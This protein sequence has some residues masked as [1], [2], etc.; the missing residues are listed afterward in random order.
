[1]SA[2][3]TVPAVR[4]ARVSFAYPGSAAPALEDIHLDVAEGE[5]VVVVGPTGCGKSTFLRAINGLVPHF[6]GGTLRGS[7]E[8]F[9]RST[10]Q[11]PP[12]E[13]A[14]AVGFVP[15]DPAD[16]FVCDSVEEELAYAMENLGVDPVAMRRRVEETLDL[17]SIVDLRDRHPSSLSGGQQQRVAIAAVLTAS[18]RILVL[19]EPTSSLDP[20]SAEEVLASLTRLVHD[21]GLTVIM[22]EHRLERVAHL[23]DRIVVVDGPRTAAELP[24]DAMT[25]SPVAPPVVELGRLAGWHPL[26]L[27]IRDARRRSRDLHDHLRSHQVSRPGDAVDVAGAAVDAVSADHVVVRHGRREALRSVSLDVPAGNVTA[28]MGRNGAGKSTLLGALAGLHRVVSGTVT[29]DGVDPHRLAGRDRIRRV[30]LVPQDPTLLLC[31]DS[32]ER[33]CRDADRDAGLEP[34]ATAAVLERLVP[35]LD[36]LRHPRRLSEG[37][38]LGLALAVVTAPAPRVLLLDEPT[39]G[40]DYAAKARLV[41]WIR[42][43]ACNG[44][45]VVVSTHDVELAAVVAHRVVVLADGEVIADGPARDVVCQSPVFAPQIAKIMAPDRWL[46]VDEIADALADARVP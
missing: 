44:T 36:P 11:H 9:G 13:L 45:A 28:V 27:S 21:V 8:V 46:T 12:R 17:L 26:P 41:A 20:A 1:M 38:R 39:R 40:L 19:D 2:A 23:A 42:E 43:L 37:Q 18:P 22:A 10:Q 30:G 4:F 14:D 7:V 33:E 29:I 35:G 31:S 6:S 5:L 34:G 32:V 16:A 24:V 15:Q 3:A 25:W